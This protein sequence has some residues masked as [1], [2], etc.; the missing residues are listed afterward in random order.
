MP[1]PENKNT[2]KERNGE[3]NKGIKEKCYKWSTMKGNKKITHY[4]V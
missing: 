2:N 4:K 1:V 3:T